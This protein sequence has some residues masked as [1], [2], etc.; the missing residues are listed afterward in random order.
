[1]NDVFAGILLGT[2]LGV[3]GAGLAVKA[4]GPK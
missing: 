2:A 4:F 1:M 3:R